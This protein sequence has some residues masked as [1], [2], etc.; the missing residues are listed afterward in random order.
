MYYRQQIAEK[1]LKFNVKLKNTQIYRNSLKFF[2]H[3]LENVF[4]LAYLFARRTKCTLMA[5]ICA[6][7]AVLYPSE[8]L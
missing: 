6:K 2:S 5:V 1:T 3:F 4:D 7:M 8:F